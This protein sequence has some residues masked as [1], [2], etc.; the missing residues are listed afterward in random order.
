MYQRIVRQRIIS[1]FD[2]LNRADASAMT[3]S[4]AADFR[5]EFHGDH[6]LGGV[7]TTSEAMIRW[8]ERVFRLLPGARFD[9]REV[10]VAGAPWNTRIAARVRV[11]GAIPGGAEYDN[12][13][14]QFMTLR[15]GR[16]CSVESL[17]DLQVLE[18]ALDAVAAAGV[19]EAHAAPITDEPEA[20]PS[21]R[22]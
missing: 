8:W 20:M 19:G 21:I 7:R 1:V 14:F 22:G 3:D 15:W 5:Y 9:V 18:R 13:I 2:S 16:V 12:T 11:R 10:L 17:E 4:L 6:A